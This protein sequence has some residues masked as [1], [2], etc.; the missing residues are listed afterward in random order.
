MEPPEITRLFSAGSVYLAVGTIEPRKNHEYLLDAFEL[1]WGAGSEARLCIIGRID[2][3]REALLKRICEHA[4][5]GRRL[6]MFNE[7]SDSGLQYAYG[8]AKALVFSSHDEGFGLPLVEAMQRGLPVMGSDIP[9]FHEIGGDYMAY[10]A[11]Q[12][13]QLAG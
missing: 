5:F 11:L 12:Q 9:V 8:H 2:W 7:I 6:F 4:E 13:P 10:F 1:A 3:K